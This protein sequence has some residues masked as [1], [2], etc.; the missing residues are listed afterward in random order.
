MGICRFCDL[1]WPLHIP[2]AKC[3][4]PRHPY[5]PDYKGMRAGMGPYCDRIRSW[6]SDKE[7]SMDSR[8]GFGA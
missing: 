7:G 5:P 1:G 4:S 8:R 2:A 6:W 3:I